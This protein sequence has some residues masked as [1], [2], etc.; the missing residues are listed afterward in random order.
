MRDSEHLSGKVLMAKCDE[1]H[2]PI[3]A[4]CPRSHKSDAVELV[5]SKN[6]SDSLFVERRYGCD[7]AIEPVANFLWKTLGTEI[8]SGFFSF[9]NGPYNEFSKGDREFVLRA[10]R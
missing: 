4:L 6:G 10:L 3:A 9:E 1:L 7:G 8:I 5:R 2:E